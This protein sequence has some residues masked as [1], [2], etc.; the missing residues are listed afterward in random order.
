[1]AYYL[2][3]VNYL[4]F[5]EDHHY[6]VS[7]QYLLLLVNHCSLSAIWS[8]LSLACLAQYSINHPLYSV[9]GFEELAVSG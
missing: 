3:F 9:A 1:M 8:F 4:P 6:H 5:R 2:F 7:H